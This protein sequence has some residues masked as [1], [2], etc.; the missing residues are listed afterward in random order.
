MKS[1]AE[2]T[3]TCADLDWHLSGECEPAT[4]ERVKNVEGV[5]WQCPRCGHVFEAKDS[6]CLQ[7][8]HRRC[9]QRL[10]GWKGRR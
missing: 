9:G 10:L 4:H 3:F 7:S 2:R 5:V 6:H 1:S 8:K